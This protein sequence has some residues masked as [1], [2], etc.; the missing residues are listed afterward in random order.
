MG[1]GAHA[2]SFA[3]FLGFFAGLGATLAAPALAQVSSIVWH[4]IGN[5]G[6]EPWEDNRHPDLK[7][8]GRGQVDHRYR[9]S[10]T[11][12]SLN[13]WVEF[14]G[15]YGPH[16]DDPFDPRL[17]GFNI[18]GSYQDGEPVYQV[19]DGFEHFPAQMS[20]R[21][22]ARFANWMHNGQ[23]DEA[24]S[25][26]SGAY[27][28]STFTRNGDGSFNDQDTHS[29]GA[30]Y[31]I[32]SMD[33]WMKAAYYDPDHSGQGVGGWWEQP[34]GGDEAL[35]SG[36]PDSGGETNAALY[37]G[38]YGNFLDV[39]QYPHVRS[40][41]GLLDLSGGMREFTEEWDSGDS[42]SRRHT[43]GA[44]VYDD[45]LF[46]SEM[47]WIGSET[48]VARPDGLGFQGLRLAAS[49]PSPPTLLLASSA[50]VWVLLRTRR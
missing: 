43:K 50:F 30:R 13:Q 21:M 36:F 26:E 12:L 2:N 34:G 44:S 45:P 18:Y 46:Y 41:W 8:N 31:W 9:M 29:P 28:S 7:F 15:A 17:L 4:E 1:F 22:A 6:N 39:G 40:P 10:E 32:P 20:W 42:P 37:D 27:N 35:V 3:R 24:W 11:E 23:I 16:A 38:S 33:E 19:Y 14:V 47:D 49:I 5:P 48:W 25:F